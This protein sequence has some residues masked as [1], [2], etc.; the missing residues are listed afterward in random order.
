MQNETFPPDADNNR[1]FRAALGRFATGITIVTILAP[2]GPMGFCAN[3]F[4]SISID[5]PLVLWAP[6][7]SSSRYTYF[8]QAR[9]YA[10]HVL[11]AD[12]RH[13]IDRFSRGGR[14]F[15]GLSHQS[16]PEGAPILPDALARFDCER[17]AAHDGGDHLIILGRVIRA[18]CRDGKPLIFCHG[19]FGGFSADV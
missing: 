16:N 2:D 8:A 4:S 7:K 9:H 11:G 14:G 3:S 18:A 10:I 19:L 13:L 1:A 5:P 6:A 15:D 12:Q 17:H